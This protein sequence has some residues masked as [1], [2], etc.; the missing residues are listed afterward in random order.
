MSN[1][2]FKTSSN[3]LTVGRKRL[4]GQFVR[5]IPET[6]H[7][8]ESWSWLR[9]ADLKIQTETEQ[10]QALGTNYVKYH[11]DKTVE[12]PLCKLRG[13]KGESVNHIVCECKKLTQR[14]YKQ[15][16]DSSVRNIIWNRRISGTNTHLTV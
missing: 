15:F 4:H 7:V 10:E 12:F 5:E 6:T 1:D 8:K 11:I 9:K 13:E 14:E 3:N 2:E 16:I